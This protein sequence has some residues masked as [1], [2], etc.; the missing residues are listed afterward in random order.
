MKN[1]YFYKFLVRK[2]HVCKYLILNSFLIFL[3]SRIIINIF[4][5]LYRRWESKKLFNLLEINKHKKIIF[6][7][8][9]KESSIAYG[10]FFY[11]CMMIRQLK[12]NK[13]N[14]KCYIIT[15]TIR[16]DYYRYFK[17]NK[18][19]NII[20]ELKLLF[21]SLCKE[22]ITEISFLKANNQI[23]K[24][25]NDY[26][27][28]KKNICLRKRVHTFYPL[29]N[30]EIYNFYKNRSFLLKSKKENLICLGIRYKYF[31]SNPKRNQS[32]DQ[33]FND[34]KYIKL[35]YPN[36]K[37][38]LMLNYNSQKYLK[39]IIS[40]KYK[41]LKFSNGKYFHKDLKILLKSKFFFCS[42]AT[43]IASINSFIDRPGNIYCN[44]SALLE[45]ILA[46][47]FFYPT[48]F[49]I[50]TMWPWLNKKIV[51]NFKSY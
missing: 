49:S 29:L 44:G 47:D 10:D 16:D 13:F 35:K 38:I 45:R 43:G 21:K 9:L 20:K 3:P 34:I 4:K 18:I 2:Y 46:N 42:T 22:E 19:K 32:V 27:F 15:D 31:K 28:H 50:K 39:K 30:K 36:S 25:I 1:S 41:N 26:I 40:K 23:Y 8:D 12:Y 11:F 33:I 7:Y 5:D 48:Q 14:V 37:I 51:V 6:F 17:K 24:N